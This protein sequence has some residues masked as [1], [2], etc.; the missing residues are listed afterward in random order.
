MKFVFLAFL[1]LLFGLW[2]SADGHHVIF[3]NIGQLAGAL[4]YLHVKMTLNLTRIHDQLINY[5]ASLYQL[6][7]FFR[8]SHP[9]LELNKDDYYVK[10]IHHLSWRMKNRAIEMLDNNI[11]TVHRLFARLS[12]LRFALPDGEAHS[13][14]IIAH[15][16]RLKRSIPLFDFNE[17]VQAAAEQTS[18]INDISNSIGRSPRFLSQLALPL[19]IFGTF[20]GLYN[21]QQIDLLRSDLRDSVTKHNRLVEVV[22]T[23]GDEL[24]KM[25]NA[26]TTLLTQLNYMSLSNPTYALS[27]CLIMERDIE[28]QLEIAEETVQQAQQ[29][30]LAIRFLS[31]DQLRLVYTKIQRKSDRSGYTLLTHHHSDLFQLETSYFY[32][33]YDVHLLLHVPIIPADSLLRLFRLHPFPLSLTND[34]MLVPNVDSDVLAISS[35]F[36]RLSA[37]LNYVDLMECHNVN[38]VYLCDQQGVLRNNINSTCLGALYQ[39]DFQA[40]QTLCPLKIHDSGEVVQQLLNNWFLL[41]SPKPLMAPVACFNGTQSEIHLKPGTSKFYLSP[42]CKTQLT[43]HLVISDINLRLDGDLLH[44]EWTWDP[45]FL[46]SLTTQEIDALT[47]EFQTAG[48]QEPTWSDLKLRQQEQKIFPTWFPFIINSAA[49]LAVFLILVGI[50]VSLYCRYRKT[51]QPFQVATK[52]RPIVRR[53]TSFHVRESVRPPIPPKPTL[54]RSQAID[55]IDVIETY[56]PMLDGPEREVDCRSATTAL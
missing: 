17:N 18:K 8:Q 3:E 53:N 54:R 28:T 24:K 49:L 6:Q 50:F 22:Q 51:F 40:V 43:S 36:T 39:Q 21:A 25:Q 44:Y 4:S 42:G 23:Q 47:D 13:D 11:R 16:I 55:D 14:Q 27:F 15:N 35:G 32:D 5:N 56:A 19:G 37:I 12:T 26:M 7:D 30:R 31:A 34:H 20:M 52:I 33:G 10:N 2:L 29:R 48:S 46:N 38:N 45:A 9:H 1:P 41:Y